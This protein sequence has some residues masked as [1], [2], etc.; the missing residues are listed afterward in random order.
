MKAQKKH[1]VINLTEEMKE[2]YHK[3]LKDQRK[4]VRNTPHYGG[5][6]YDHEYARTINILNCDRLHY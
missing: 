5:T 3:H 6:S 4:K 2:F 1:H